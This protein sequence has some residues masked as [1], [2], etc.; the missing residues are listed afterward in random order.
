MQAE[1]KERGSCGLTAGRCA[2][3][4]KDDEVGRG[5]REEEEEKEKG[6][7]RRKQKNRSLS[8]KRR[9]SAFCQTVAWKFA[10]ASGARRAKGEGGR[11]G[12]GE[13][14]WRGIVE[15]WEWKKDEQ[16]RGGGG[17]G[18]AP[19]KEAAKFRGTLRRAVI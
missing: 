19:K 13:I 14:G 5:R 15:W 8:G 7:R 6:E 2:A 17:G 10:G 9:K 16:R 4:P 1:K 18:L 11:T 12:Q 3:A